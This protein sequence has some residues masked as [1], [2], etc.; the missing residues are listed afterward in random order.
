VVAPWLARTVF[1]GVA[2]AA[3]YRAA[4]AAAGAKEQGVAAAFVSTEQYVGTAPA[5]P[6][7]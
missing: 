5:A 4:G 6:R 2:F 7:N 1:A 3:V